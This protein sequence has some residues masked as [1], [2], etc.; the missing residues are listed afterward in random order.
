MSTLTKTTT[1]SGGDGVVIY[2]NS[3]GDF[4]EISFTN[5]TA[6][7][8][9]ALTLGRAEAY[10]QYAAPSA[11]GFSVQILDED[12]D[13]HLILTPGAGYA[14]GEIVLPNVANCRD[15]QEVTVNCTQTIGTLVVNGN[16]AIAVTGAPAAIAAANEFFKMCYDK[17]T[18]T[19]YRIG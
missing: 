19:W 14:D 4:R 5:L 6:A 15:K 13:V 16:G 7:L 3:Q 2:S 11:T 10:T 9:S 1:I 17:P 8:Q 12:Q 18:S